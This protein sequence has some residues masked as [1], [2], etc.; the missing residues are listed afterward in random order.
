MKTI[1]AV[2]SIAIDTVQTQND[3]R[4]N[5]L[6]GSAVFFSLAASLFAPVIMVG[7]VGNDYPKKGWRLFKSRNIN[8]D[9]VQILS[10]KTFE[11]LRGIQNG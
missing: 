4:D 10:G 9:N 7:V 5:L 8:M 3:H 11:H 1:L 6:G 2:G